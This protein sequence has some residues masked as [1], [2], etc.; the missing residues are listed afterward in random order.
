MAAGQSDR[1][2]HGFIF[3]SHFKAGII[4]VIEIDSADHARPLAEALLAGGLPI[5]EITLRTE[6]A[7]ESIRRITSSAI[8]PR[9]GGNSH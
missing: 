8:G 5:A 7:F 2:I 1:I 3:R 4:P 9:W 6:A